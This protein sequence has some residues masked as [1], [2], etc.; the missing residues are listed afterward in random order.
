LVVAPIDAK[1]FRRNT[2]PSESNQEASPYRSYDND[3]TSDA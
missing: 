3:D 2:A 1:G